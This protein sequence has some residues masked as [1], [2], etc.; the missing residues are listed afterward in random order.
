M[1]S[2]LLLTIIIALVFAATGMS[3]PLITL[4]LEG[5]GGD[6]QHISL[7]MATAAAMALVS[8]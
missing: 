4:Y 8:N 3:S 5:L 2:I 1:D 7:I 6:Y